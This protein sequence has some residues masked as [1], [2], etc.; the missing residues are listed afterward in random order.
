MM[1]DRPATTLTLS[2]PT[3]EGTAIVNLVILV[4]ASRES[5]RGFAREAASVSPS[6]WGEVRGEGSRY[7]SIQS[8]GNR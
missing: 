8:H 4:D 3:G 2:R 1:N 7:N 6:P 5:S